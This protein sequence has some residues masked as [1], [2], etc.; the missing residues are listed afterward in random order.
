MI[1]FSSH[2]SIRQADPKKFLSDQADKYWKSLNPKIGKSYGKSALIFKVK[3]YRDLARNRDP[4]YLQSF[5]NN[6]PAIAKEQEKFLSHLLAHNNSLLKQIVTAGPADLHRLK[7]QFAAQFNSDLFYL[8]TA[9]GSKQSK[10]GK[11]LSDDIFDYKK[12]RSSK[13]CFDFLQEVTFG[14]IYC[15]YC[16]QSEI[17]FVKVKIGAKNVSRKALLDLDHFFSK[18]ENPYLAISL[19]NLIP[20]CGTCNSRFKGTKEFTLTTH[21]HPY[22]ESFDDY[23]IFSL[24]IDPAGTTY[25][26]I[27][28]KMPSG[29]T[30]SST[31]F[32]LPGRYIDH[33]KLLQIQNDYNSN[34]KYTDEDKIWFAKYMLKD[35][36]KKAGHILLE[37]HG[38][39]KRDI[40]IELDKHQKLLAKELL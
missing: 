8:S 11:L 7:S 35:V 17:K 26:S 39:A 14:P 16:G 36:P 4:M 10:F 24:E 19:F 18:V 40:L 33:P 32:G 15:P 29:K 30:K 3:E 28:D 13:F 9:K 2:L 25:V 34:P 5:A 12:Y 22:V 31:D 38:K 1:V 6:N 21:I 27:K 37:F 20:C 23:F